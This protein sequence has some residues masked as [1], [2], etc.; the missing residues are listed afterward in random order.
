MNWWYRFNQ[1][2]LQVLFCSLFRLRVLGRHNVPREGAVL[3]LGN[4]QSFFDPPLCGV[5]LVRELDYVARESLFKNRFFGRLISSLN[6]FPLQRDSA[7]IAAFREIIRR[8]SRGRALVLFPEGTRTPDGR[9]RPMKSGFELIARKSGA[10]IVPV[11]V[12]GAFEAWPRSQPLPGLGRIMVMYGEPITAE[13][14]AQLG[15]A[16]L[17]EEINRRLRQM[18]NDLRRRL[19]KAVYDYPQIQAR[20]I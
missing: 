7:D 8:L 3:L 16:E 18:Q 13:Q 12:D 19:G 1:C 20:D 4:H 9:I 10:T 5:G 17:V 2:G 15:R 14:A 6:A 11:V